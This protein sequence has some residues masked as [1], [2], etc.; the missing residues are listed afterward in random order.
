MKIPNAQHE[1]GPWRIREVAP[2][3]ILEDA[4]ALPAYGDARLARSLR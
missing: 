1:S 3:F 4:W 2:D